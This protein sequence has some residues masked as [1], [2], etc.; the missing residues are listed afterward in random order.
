MRGLRRTLSIGFAIATAAGLALATGAA[1]A[2]KF[3]VLHAFCESKHR[4]CGDGSNPSGPLVM[5][6]AGNFF[7]TTQPAG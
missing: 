6:Q 1:Q 4:P 2:G 3:K 7:G 5:D